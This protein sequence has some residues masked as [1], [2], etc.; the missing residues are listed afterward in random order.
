MSR[1]KGFHHTEET[2]KQISKS[3][4]GMKHPLY[5]KHHTNEWKK[6]MSKLLSGKNNPF[7]G[8]HHTEKTKQK[9]SNNH[10]ALFGVNHPLWKGNNVKYAALHTWIK[11]N[12]PKPYTCEMCNEREPHD[13]ANISGKYKRDVD[14]FQWLCVPCHRRYDNQMRGV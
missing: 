14:D 3:N 6:H 9:M 8:R 11:R 13:L 5:G 1:Q 12:K 10:V 7:Y 2:K 4:K